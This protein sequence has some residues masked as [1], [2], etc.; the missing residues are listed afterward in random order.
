MLFVNVFSTIVLAGSVAAIPF[1]VLPPQSKRDVNPALVP[2]FGWPSGVNPDG[3]GNCD[4][5][6]NGTNGKPILV[7]CQCPPNS[8]FFLASLNKNVAAGFVTTNPTV[9]LSF[10]TDNS[11]ASQNARLNAAA[12]TLQNLEGPGVGCPISSTTFSAQQKAINAETSTTGSSGAIPSMSTIAS[13]APISS[14]AVS[15]MSTATPTTPAGCAVPTSTASTSSV[16]PTASTNSSVSPT[17]AQIATLAPPLGWQSGINPDGTGNCDGSVNGT[18]GKPILIPCQCPPDQTHYIA[19]LTA[20]IRAG[21]VILNP[22]VLLTFPTDNSTAAQN[23]RLNAAA[24]TI[25]NLNGAGKGCPIVSTSFSAQQKAIN[26]EST[27]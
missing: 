14:S 4:G 20:N 17:D 21:H 15:A 19:N 13:S 12:V 22:T 27:S 25:Q 11:T 5:A 6:V 8:T 7:P 10:P 18:N 16:S 2:S 1:R 9:K 23:A 26:A 24:V 3:T